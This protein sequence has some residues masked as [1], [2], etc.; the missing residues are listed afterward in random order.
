MTTKE[1]SITLHPDRGVNPRVTVCT[2]CG[3]DIGVALLGVR[4]WQWKCGCG[5]VNLG[6]QRCPP[7]KCESCGKRGVSQCSWTNIGW[8]PDTA[9]IPDGLCDACEARRAECAAEVERG[10]VWWRCKTCG[11]EGAIKADHPLAKDVRATMGIEAPKACG[12]TF[13]PA[14]CPICNGTVES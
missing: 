6:H 8:L 4:D 2:G 3:A 7:R 10:G 14:E 5:A 11:S 13:T 12:V 9:K 1:P